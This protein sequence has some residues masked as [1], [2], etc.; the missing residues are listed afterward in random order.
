MR[1]DEE[2]P[3]ARVHAEAVDVIGLLLRDDIRRGALG[4]RRRILVG[5]AGHGDGDECAQE[6]VKSTGR[7]HGQS[8]G[9]A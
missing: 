6:G 8:Y 3:V 2:G 7:R 4:R 1:G 5:A 9:P